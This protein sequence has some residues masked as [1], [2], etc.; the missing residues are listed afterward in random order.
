MTARLVGVSKDR[1]RRWVKGYD[2]SYSSADEIHKV[3]KAPVIQ[4]EYKGGSPYITFFEL[5]D[6]L[7]VKQFLSW[8]FTQKIRNAL[9]RLN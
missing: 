9:K 3:K 1:V 8:I 6:L 5:I 4:R 2:Y 7:F